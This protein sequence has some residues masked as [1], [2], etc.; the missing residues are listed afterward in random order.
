MPGKEPT[1]GMMLATERT[2]NIEV[3]SEFNIKKINWLLIFTLKSEPSSSK[4]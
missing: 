3:I 2:S 4:E 1:K